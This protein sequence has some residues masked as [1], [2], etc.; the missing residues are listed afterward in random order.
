MFEYPDNLSLSDIEDMP[1]DVYYGNSSGEIVDDDLPLDDGGG[2]EQV[3]GFSPEIQRSFEMYED[4]NAF[5]RGSSMFRELDTDTF[6]RLIFCRGDDFEQLPFEEEWCQAYEWWTEH[7]RL[8]KRPAEF[9]YVYNGI[10][11][12]IYGKRQKENKNKTFVIT[13]RAER[14][15]E[16]LDHPFVVMSPVSYTGKRRTKT[17]ARYLYAIGI[18]IDSVDADNI[19]NLLY[20][21]DPSRPHIT[22]PQPQIIVNSGGGIHVYFLLE[23][24]A[25]MFKDAYPILNKIKKELTRRIWNKGT[26]HEDPNS[27]QFQGNCQGFRLPGTQTKFYKKV[28]AF[29][30]LNPRVKPYYSISDLTF[31]G[32]GFLTD[33]EEML[34]KRG[35]YNPSRVSLAQARELYPEWY[36]RRIIQGHKPN[37]WYVKRDLYDWWKVQIEQHASV[38]HRYFCLMALAVYAKKCDIPEEEF[39]ADLMGFVDVMDGLSYTDNEED[40]FTVEDALDAAAAFQES[41]CTFP[42]DDL[43]DITGIEITRNQTRKFKKQKE[44]LEEAR[45]IRDLRQK[46][47]GTIWDIDKGRNRK[48]EQV[49]AWRQEHLGGTKYA[50]AKEL[51]IDKKTVFRWWNTTAEDI[52]REAEIKQ[53]RKVA[54]LAMASTPGYDDI[55]AGERASVHKDLSDAINFSEIAADSVMRKLGIPEVLIPMLRAKMMAEMSTTEFWEQYRKERGGMEIELP[56]EIRSSCILTV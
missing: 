13:S 54:A 52:Q 20:Q 37:R 46:K 1:D 49:F 30:N 2:V 45:A 3:I 19:R 26:T 34:L 4:K 16:I 31:G 29:Q 47:N 18:D 21:S 43:R 15:H 33:E 22:F 24:P 28:T 23:T 35:T 55:P 41:Y 9:S 50:C 8:A 42:L 7:D 39:K 44:H 5:L 40:R 14:L 6:I 53:A 56:S 10:A 12:A 17:N 36:E 38:G 48:Q 32:G 25:A 51:G 27:P 11:Q